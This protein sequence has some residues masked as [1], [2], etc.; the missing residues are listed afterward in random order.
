MRSA[1]A[2]TPLLV[3]YTAMHGVGLE[4]AK[5]AFVAA[6]FPLEKLSIVESQAQPDPMFPSVAFPN[7]EE[8]GALVSLSMES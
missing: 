2:A 6:G 5:R 1:N 7:P 4:F 8:K 3:T